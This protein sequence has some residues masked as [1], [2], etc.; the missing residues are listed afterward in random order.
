[1]DLLLL[2]LQLLH[3][4]KGTRGKP[5]LLL[6]S[7]LLIRAIRVSHSILVSHSKVSHSKLNKAID[8]RLHPRDI[9]QGSMDNN[10]VMVLPVYHQVASHKACHLE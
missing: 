3:Q 1:M 5:H 7:N 4:D 2:A 9:T 10:Q 8:P 6:A